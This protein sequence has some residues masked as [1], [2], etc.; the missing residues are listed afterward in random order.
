MSKRGLSARHSVPNQTLSLVNTRLPKG[1]PVA[2]N[3]GRASGYGAPLAGFHG[4]W[5]AAAPPVPSPFET[6]VW[7]PP[8][9]EGQTGW[10]GYL[11]VFASATITRSETDRHTRACG[12]PVRRGFSVRSFGVS[13]ILGH[14]HARVTTTE[15]A[16]AIP[17]HGLPEVCIFVCPSSKTEGAGKT[18]CAL[19]PRSRV[20]MRTAK[21]HTSIQVQR[22]H[23]G[24]PCAVVLRLTSCS[25][26]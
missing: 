25:P 23:S 21:T 2:G 17:R 12:Y 18:G 11:R 10:R 7:R 20:Q 1:N 4:P 14:P 22:K 16:V 15:Y 6:G 24:L 26:R 5:D 8:Q 3:R 13:G 19:H 9:G